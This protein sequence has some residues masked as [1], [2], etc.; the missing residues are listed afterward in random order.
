[1]KRGKVFPSQGGCWFCWNETE[2]MVFDTEFDTLVHPQCILSALA[3]DPEHPEAR[4]M[5][6]LVEDL[7]P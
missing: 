2:G 1:M 5:F 6:Y 4:L 3:D 7:V